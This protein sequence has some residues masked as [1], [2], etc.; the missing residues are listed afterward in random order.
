M[1]KG[2]LA[3]VLILLCAT[4]FANPV[5]IAY[6]DTRRIANE[7]NKAID[8][9][10]KLEVAQE[11]WNEELQGYIKDMQEKYESL[12][13]N[14]A[15][16]TEDKKKQAQEEFLGLQERYENRKRDVYGQDGLYDQKYVEIMQPVIEEA[17]KVISEIAKKEQYTV[18]LDS[19]TE[20]IIYLDENIDITDTVLAE[21]NK[22]K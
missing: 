7:Y 8:A 11:I 18:V 10:K 13:I 6:V 4:I 20:T 16:W 22:Q 2:I 19:I 14:E 17:R 21:L 12:Q 9:N 3:L 5:K 1:K 15:V